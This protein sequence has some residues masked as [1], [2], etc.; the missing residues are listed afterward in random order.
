MLSISKLQHGICKVEVTYILVN[1][2]GVVSSS[3]AISAIH[4]SKTFMVTL[5][6]TN[7]DSESL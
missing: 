1:S 5:I 4:S 3:D 7:N 6:L 2:V